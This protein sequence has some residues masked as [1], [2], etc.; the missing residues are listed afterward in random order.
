MT[1]KRTPSEVLVPRGVL[2]GLLTLVLVVKPLANVMGYHIC[3]DGYDQ[4]H[5]DLYHL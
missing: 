2:L 1:Q 3:S 4:I 5:Y